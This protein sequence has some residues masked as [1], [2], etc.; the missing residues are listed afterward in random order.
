MKKKKLGVVLFSGRKN[1]IFTRKIKKFIKKKS[2]KFYYIES[3]KIGEKLPKSITKIRCEGRRQNIKSPQE[4]VSPETHAT[5]RWCEQ[6]HLA[7]NG[8]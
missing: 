2:D 4:V 6:P 5:K 3:T 8:N 1:C 7:G